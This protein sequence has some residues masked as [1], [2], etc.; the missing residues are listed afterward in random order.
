MKNS[1]HQPARAG[2]RFLVLSNRRIGGESDYGRFEWCHNWADRLLVAHTVS[3]CLFC[4][5]GFYYVGAMDIKIESRRALAKPTQL[6]AV[7]IDSERARQELRSSQ[8]KRGSFWAGLLDAA[9]VQLI[10]RTAAKRKFEGKSKQTLHVSVLHQRSILEVLFVGVG[11]IEKDEASKLSVSR[12]AGAVVSEQA[13]RLDATDVAVV[14]SSDQVKVTT[15]DDRFLR[16]LSD[17]LRLASYRFDKFKSKEEGDSS[18]PKSKMKVRLL[19]ASSY[20]GKSARLDES[21]RFCE[22]TSLARDLVNLPAKDCTPKVLVS[23]ARRLAK[24]YKLSLEVFDTKKLERM[25]ARALLAVAQGSD[26]PPYLIRLAYKPRRSSKKC[27]SLVGKGV[28][29]DSG[30]YSIKSASGMESMKIDMSGAA[31]VLG[32]MSIIASLGCPHEVRAYIPTVENMVSGGAIRPG[33]IVKG[34]SGKSIEIL[35]TDAEGRLILSDALTLAEREGCSQIIDV[36]TLTGACMVA[37]GAEYGGL[38][39]DND[40]LAT[41]L[42]HA[43]RLEGEL[44]WRMPLAPEYRDLIKSPIA[45]IKNT[46]GPYG[47]AIT[48]ALFLKEFVHKTP[49]A[50]LDI[51]GPASSDKDRGFIRRGGTGFATR[52]LA[53]YV[54]DL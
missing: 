19:V 36:A 41:K 29:F 25:N 11:K 46:G 20:R 48:A 8:S 21:A 12:Q 13:H 17:G 10:L 22:G 50:H 27:V 51:A 28:T 33:D 45:D 31:A 40:A 49:W 52:T 35:N 2:A 18:K 16:G 34:I 54:L 7:L 6:L 1:F 53:R 9:A 38:F 23:A 14:V 43:A 4:R 39:S 26:E 42:M 44:L 30:G 15:G 47:G 5:P 37:L 24:Q 3:I 32:A